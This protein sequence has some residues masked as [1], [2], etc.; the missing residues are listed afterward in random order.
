MTTATQRDVPFVSHF[1][2][3]FG[4]TEKE[5]YRSCSF[6]TTDRGFF[7][8]SDNDFLAVR[9]APDPTPCLPETARAQTGQPAGTRT[10]SL[11]ELAVDQGSWC[12]CSRSGRRRQDRPHN[13]GFA[14]ASVGLGAAHQE[15]R[16]RS[17]A[18]SLGGRAAMWQSFRFA[19]A[20]T[21]S[22]RSL[23][24]SPPGLR[25]EEAEEA[26]EGLRKTVMQR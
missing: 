22:W 5:P 13:L 14:E 26:E 6:D 25:K 10:D 19:T 7:T 3:I 21:V 18:A 17:G 1:V 8:A 20:K 24:D 23:L 4:R 2:F 9:P 15:W 11:A 12:I 16:A